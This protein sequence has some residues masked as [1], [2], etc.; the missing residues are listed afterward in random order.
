MKKTQLG[1]FEEIVLLVIAVLDEEAYGIAIK[2]EIEDRIKRNVS[3]GALQTAFKRMED[4][5]F[6]SSRLGEPTQKR[7]G[8]RKRYYAITTYGVQT[9]DEIRDIRA[10]LWSAIPSS[11]LDYRA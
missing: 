1:E 5:G 8:K 11:I 7:G 10:K 9:L 4:K 3:I 6:I 2:K